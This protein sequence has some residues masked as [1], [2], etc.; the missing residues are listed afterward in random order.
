LPLPTMIRWL[1]KR[2]ITSITLWFKLNSNWIWI[3]GSLFIL[4]K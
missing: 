2:T 3:L 1:K 4:S